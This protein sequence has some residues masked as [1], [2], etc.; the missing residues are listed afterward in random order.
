MK[1]VV[2]E[3]LV[4]MSSMALYS[5][6][7]GTTTYETA[8]PY[9]DK[10][11]VQTGLSKS[12]SIL[13]NDAA[14]NPFVVYRSINGNTNSGFKLEHEQ[15]MENQIISYKLSKSELSFPIK[16]NKLPELKGLFPAP[17]IQTKKQ[18]FKD[19]M[20]VSLESLESPS[21]LYYSLNGSDKL[22]QYKALFY[23]Y[24]TTDIK[25]LATD[26]S[27]NRKNESNAHF[28]LIPHNWSIML[29]SK[30]TKPYTGG[31]DDALI[32]GI[33]GDENWRKGLW[34]GYWGQ[35]FEAIIDLQKM[36]KVKTVKASFLQDSKS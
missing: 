14:Q 13:A 36:K 5:V 11:V 30:I 23:I 4:V 31:G 29:K 33:R 21:L 10:I 1:I 27:G 24:K 9:F 32:D 7:P 16:E 2:N 22:I 17:L 18:A 25:C 26:L 28:H 35:D 8:A 12:F 20:L 6:C 34:Q 19:S 15:L 3:C